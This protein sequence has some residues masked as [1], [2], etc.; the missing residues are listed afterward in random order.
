M[1]ANNKTIIIKLHYKRPPNIASVYDGLKT[2]Q[3]VEVE[4]N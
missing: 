1:R 4:C 2:F 3:N